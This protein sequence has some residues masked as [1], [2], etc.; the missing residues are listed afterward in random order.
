MN[1]TWEE[2]FV[3]DGLPDK[4]LRR[5]ACRI[6][7][8][9]VERPGAAMTGAFDFW[10]DTRTAYNFFA[11]ERVTF[12]AVL[13]SPITVVSRALRERFEGTTVLNV[14][15]TTEINLSHLN[16]M[17]GLGEIGNPM[18][19]GLFL[20][21]S[22]AVSPDGVP[23]GL[24]SAQVWD[25]PP[26]SH[27]KTKKRKQKA[28]EEKESLRWWTAIEESEKRVGRPGLL[29]HVADRESD[30][31]DVFK[32]AHDAGYRILV[33]AAQDRRVEGEHSTLWA[34][35]A[36]FSPAGEARPL[37]VPMRPAKEGKPARAARDTSIVIRYGLVTLREP[38]GS[39]TV[40][41]H[42][43]QVTEVD[44]PVGVEPIEWLLLTTDSIMSVEDAWQRV[45]W[46]RCR[47]RIEEF[48]QV[49]KSGCRIEARQ[50][51]SRS[52]YEPS[53]AIAMLTAVRLL[54][55]VKQARVTPDAPASSVL[56]QEEEHVLVQHAQAK[57]MGHHCDS[58][59]LHLVDAVVLIAMLGGYKA[60][61]C[62]GPP[63]WITLWRGLRRLED[64]VEGYRLALPEPSRPP[65]H[66]PPLERGSR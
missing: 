60:R 32:R 23:I 16:S 21:P 31:Y 15:D 6:A 61:S 48:F 64:M 14:Q 28:F 9:S 63:G 26:S 52:T 10:K 38:K 22:L 44:P 3:G 35:V 65:S 55:M 47:W 51:E 2:L 24:L 13:D 36:S 53:L 25:R 50:F 1:L 17:T 18:N 42:A 39:G 40:E 20:H 56:S 46:Y 37:S 4:R 11:N 54:T 34:Q 57:K 49:L 29:V 30:I 45:E 43:V 41:M 66:R 19:R 27:G 62:D 12:S 5:R 33:R 59:P 7:H 58:S 8:A